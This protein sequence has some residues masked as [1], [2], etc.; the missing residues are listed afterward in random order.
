MAVKKQPVLAGKRLIAGLVL[1][2]VAM[3]GFGYALV[4]LYDLICEVT[5]LNGKTGR[6]EATELTG[7]DETRS[8]QVQFVA[9]VNNSG[10]W[11]FVP[12]DVMLKVHP[13]GV[14]TTSYRAK[15]RTNMRLVGQA[16]PSVVPR[17]GSL[18][19]S[20]M[21]C[22]CFTR[23]VFEAGEERDM[24]VRFVV[25]RKLPAHVESLV[26]SYTFFEVNEQS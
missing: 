3:F 20:K 2:T 4:P 9:S 26:L 23:Q 8:V 13:G 7:V 6:I 1:A 18:Y 5:G 24:P 16:V 11:E 21:E 14:Y 15:N 25:D 10:P 22:F 17:E 12:N 19:L